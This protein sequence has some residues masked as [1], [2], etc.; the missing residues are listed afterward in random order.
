M[1]NPKKN[2]SSLFTDS[3]KLMGI[4]G[5]TAP[6]WMKWQHRTDVVELFKKYNRGKG[7]VSKRSIIEKL[8]AIPAGEYAVALSR[9][10]DYVET[11]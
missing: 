9:L 6:K 8:S 5:L 4:C 10:I 2:F 3:L 11:A 1:A 7:K